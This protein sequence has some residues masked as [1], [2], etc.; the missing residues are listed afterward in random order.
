MKLLKIIILFLLAGLFLNPNFLSGQSSLDIV[1]K[2]A[3]K[4]IRESSFEFDMVQQMP[5]LGMQIVDFKQNFSEQASGISYAMSY[6]F[7]EKD[8][9][10]LFGFS[11]GNPM[12]IWLNDKIVLSQKNLKLSIPKEISYNCFTFQDTLNFNLR[13]GANKIMLKSFSDT[14]NWIFISSGQRSTTIRGDLGQLLLREWR[15]QN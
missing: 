9:S 6:I 2:V 4:V 10:A 15:F 8:T 1:K 11:C 3:D 7:S 5:V 14:D 13:K 12:K